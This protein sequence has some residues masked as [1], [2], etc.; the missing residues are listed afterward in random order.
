MCYRNRIGWLAVCGVLAATS[1][2]GARS[3]VISVDVDQSTGSLKVTN[4]TN[5]NLTAVA[6]TANATVSP[7]SKFKARREAP[8]SAYLE[9]YWVWG[10]GVVASNV[11][12]D[13]ADARVRKFP[14]GE[15]IHSVFFP[16]GYKADALKLDRVEVY[17]GV[18]PLHENPTDFSNLPGIK[19]PNT[20]NWIVALRGEQWDFTQMSTNEV[21]GD[22]SINGTNAELVVESCKP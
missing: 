12:H 6:V 9:Q 17:A 14:E 1:S 13:D 2:A 11:K 7:K 8:S 21:V 16:A 4:Y 19:D 15:E 5:C 3:G 10:A 20:T 18:T 22:W